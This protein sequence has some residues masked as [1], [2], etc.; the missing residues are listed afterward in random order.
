MRVHGLKEINAQLLKLQ[1]A[2]AAK[3]LAEAARK[4]FAPVLEDARA[5]VPRDTE[6]LQESLRISVVKNGREYA[7]RVGI[8]IATPKAKRKGVTR[9]RS[10]WHFIE[11]GTAKHAAQPFLRPALDRN[12]TK[13]VRLLRDSL[14]AEIRNVGAGRRPTKRAA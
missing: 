5:Y 4:A 13:V 1:T 8:A 14:A 3:V 11:L 9:P 12:A 6:L 7:V 2:L 10:R